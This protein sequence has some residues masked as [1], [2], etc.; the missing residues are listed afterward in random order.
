MAQSAQTSRILLGPLNLSCNAR[1]VDM[2]FS[3]DALDVTV[4]C[5][6]SPEFIAGKD[7]SSFSAGGPLD[8][9]GAADSPFDIFSDFQSEQMPITYAP[10]GLTAGSECMLAEAMRTSF[11]SENS[12]SGSADYSLECQTNGGT[13]AGQILD[14]D[15]VTADGDGAAVDGGASSSN[16]GAATLHVTAFSGFTSDAV[17][18]EQSADGSTGWTTLVTFAT[19]TGLTSEHVEVASGTSVARYLRAS[20]DVTGTGS[21]TATVAF[22][23]R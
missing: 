3:V 16:G 7:S 6:D 19:A 9:D 15:T 8:V 4:L 1:S 18:I 21:V 10:S 23:R 11:T 17:I 13:D 5:D 12:Q 22:A 2:S 14:S 20:H